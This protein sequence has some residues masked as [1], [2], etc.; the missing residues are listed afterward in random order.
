VG[1]IQEWLKPIS[2]SLAPIYG[3]NSFDDEQARVFL[4]AV[5]EAWIDTLDRLSQLDD[6][7]RA[8]GISNLV[9]RSFE[10]WRTLIGV[11]LLNRYSRELMLSAIDREWADYLTAMEDLRQGIG[12]QGIAQRDPLVAYKT[13]AYKM[14]EEL[15]D[16][17]DRTTV[18]TYF[19]NLP[20]FVNTVQQQQVTTAGRPRELKVG[21]N[22]PCP[23]GSGKKF[24]KCHGAINRTVGA[25]NSAATAV[26]AGAAAATPVGDGGIGIATAQAPQRPQTQQQQQRNNGQQGQRRKSKGRDVPKR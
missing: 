24:K 5:N 25:L 23:C 7:Q 9:D 6:N 4:E 8:E 12:L 10:R 1:L 17:I 18:R 20:R 21:P 19:Q 2:N 26:T 14:F 13:Q 22:E 11:D 15:L 16:T 3:G